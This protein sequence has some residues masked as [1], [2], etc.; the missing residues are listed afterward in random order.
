MKLLLSGAM[1]NCMGHS[2]VKPS[3]HATTRLRLVL[4]EFG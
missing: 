4:L 1:S 2:S 3:E